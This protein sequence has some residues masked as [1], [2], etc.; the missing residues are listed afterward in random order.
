MK[1]A[2]KKLRNSLQV[3]IT[4]QLP[5]SPVKDFIEI[6]LIGQAAHAR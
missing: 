2:R 1:K 4:S 3:S 5:L 6:I